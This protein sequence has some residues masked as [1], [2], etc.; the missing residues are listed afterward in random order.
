[1]KSS[2]SRL[3]TARVKLTLEALVREHLAGNGEDAARSKT[4]LRDTH[5]KLR[6]LRSI[7]STSAALAWAEA[8]EHGMRGFI[9]LGLSDATIR[10]HC[11]AGNQAIFIACVIR[12]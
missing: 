10:P 6:F 9:E 4:K 11:G 2:S 5:A 7:L 12:N 3:A 1:M 8:E